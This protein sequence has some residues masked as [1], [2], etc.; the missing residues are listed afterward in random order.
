MSNTTTQIF[1]FDN[2][3][4][5]IVLIDGEP[6]WVGSDIAKLLGYANPKKAVIDHCSE[7]GVTIQYPITDR[8]GR[9][10]KTNLIN[11]SGLYYLIFKSKLEKAKD[12]RIWV[13][14]EVLPTLRK[15]GSY[16]LIG[17]SNHTDPE[18]AIFW[19]ELQKSQLALQ[20]NQE[21]AI[22]YLQNA[23][24]GETVKVKE[25][26]TKIEEEYKPKSQFAETVV[27]SDT[28]YAI[29]DVAKAFEIPE[30]KLFRYLRNS[31][32]LFYS[33]NDQG[34][35][36]NLPYAKYQAAGYFTVKN[37]STTVSTGKKQLVTL[38][39]GESYYEDIKQTQIWSQTR[40]TGHGYV[41]LFKKLKKDNFIKSSKVLTI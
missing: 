22:G 24:K 10:Q 28:T 15:S 18:K 13:T 39:S 3:D 11:E 32:I 2:S 20:K 21:I 16:S 9:E 17:N 19:A 37:V 26:E 30:Q 7:D 8:L 1:N 41:W 5:R 38:E 25:L 27:A 23:L 4:V 35:Q 36:V 40:V 14:K 33:K 6:H 34:R 31:D 12:F 29:K